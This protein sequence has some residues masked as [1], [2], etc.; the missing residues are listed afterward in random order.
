MAVLAPKD[1]SGLLDP[2]TAALLQAGF[3]GLA[4]SGPSRT[5]VGLGQVFGQAGQAGVNA[6]QKTVAAEQARKLQESQLAGQA[7][8]TK[9]REAEA[10]EAARATEAQK[11]FQ[12]RLGALT[13]EGQQPDEISVLGA[14][15]ETG[16]FK[17]KDVTD[18]M[19][20]V[21]ER[22]AARE[23]R[24]QE[25]QM[26]IDREDKASERH[27]ALQRELVQ[28]RA[29][30][31]RDTQRLAAAL[32]PAR[33]Q[34]LT[35][36]QGIFSVGENGALA[37]AVH[38]T[39][40]EPLRP[41]SV[42]NQDRADVRSLSG[43]FERVVKQPRQ[44]ME[45]HNTYAAARASGDFSQAS[46]A[47]ALAVQQMSRTGN[48]VFKGE[49]EKILGG[50]YGGGTVFERLSNFLSTE[51]ASGTPT[52]ETLGKLDKLAAALNSAAVLSLA[53]ETKRIADKAKARGVNPVAVTG[54]PQVYG[55]AVILPDGSHKFF[56][57]PQKAKQAADAWIEEHGVR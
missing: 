34:F 43:E 36:D 49:A 46:Q 13:A 2:T 54:G 48:R 29:D 5:P 20:K 42:L 26:R 32:K 8:L 40:G 4:A 47:M 56:A 19:G 31:S 3:S 57:N 41:P 18:F 45:A 22:K 25:L 28:M 23:Q 53:E 39:T 9:Q 38:P 30:A 50:G 14:G 7:A 37:P 27:A 10:A 17:P 52:N 55:N 44:S 15:I 35:S 12:E 6:Y 11:K 24:I 21:M 51:F 1:P 33:Q 16:A